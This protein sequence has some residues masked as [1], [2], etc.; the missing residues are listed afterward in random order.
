MSGEVFSLIGQ[1]WLLQTSGP[2]TNW[3]GPASLELGPAQL[4]PW[5][6]P[7][8]SL[9]TRSTWALYR[10]SAYASHV[11][12]LERVGWLTSRLELRRLRKSERFAMLTQRI[13]S[14]LATLTELQ[15]RYDMHHSN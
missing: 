1:S 6:L 12:I 13:L 5:P 14:R 10:A 7:P 4:Q 8:T 3:R 2:Q 15:P 9:F 11:S